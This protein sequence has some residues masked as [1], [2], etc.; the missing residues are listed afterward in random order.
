MTAGM[1]DAVRRAEKEFIRTQAKLRSIR[2]KLQDT[3]TKV[4][5]KDRM[6]TVTIDQRGMVAAIDFHSRKFQRMA[7]AELGSALLEAVRQAQSQ[8]RDR[9]LR[10]YLPLM[11][12]GM[13]RDGMPGEEDPE[14]R[15]EEARRRIA[16]MANDFHHGRDDQA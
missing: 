1:E 2:E 9:V 11:P 3:Q 4:R 7:P 12:E 13:P 5:S 10:A 6:V 16:E 15:F 14:S 8:A